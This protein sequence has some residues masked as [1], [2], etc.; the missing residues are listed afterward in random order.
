MGLTFREKNAI[1]K[2]LANDHFIEK[3]KELLRKHLPQEKLLYRSYSLSRPDLSFDILFVLLDFETAE[4]IQSNRMKNG[5]AVEDIRTEKTDRP[6][7]NTSRVQ[8]P[9]KKKT[10]KQKRKSIPGSGGQSL[11]TRISV[12]HTRCTQIVSTVTGECACLRRSWMKTQHLQL[13]LRWQSLVSGICCAF[14][15]LKR[16]ITQA[17]SFTST[18]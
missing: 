15:N 10:K 18:L 9:E 12:M 13:S 6:R 3:D 4:S 7:K 16:S 8:S 14:V 1:A 2:E 11:K 5:N 17:N